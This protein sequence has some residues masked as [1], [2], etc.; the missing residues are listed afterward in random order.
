MSKALLI[1]MSVFCHY[2]CCSCCYCC[3]LFSFYGGASL[4]IWTR[5]D[6]LSVGL[7]ISWCFI[8]YVDIEKEHEMGKSKHKLT[9]SAAIKGFA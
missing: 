1:L 9:L 7:L 8:L 2:C 4:G 6:P 3:C 5:K